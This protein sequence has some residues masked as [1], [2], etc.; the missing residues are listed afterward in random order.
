MKEAIHL[1]IDF[2]DEFEIALR[3][4]AES[5]DSQLLFPATGSLLLSRIEISS[6][7]DGQAQLSRE[8][9]LCA[10][11]T[12]GVNYSLAAIKRHDVDGQLCASTQALLAILTDQVATP[13]DVEAVFPHEESLSDA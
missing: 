9:I 8:Q 12:F 13:A 1:L 2:G 3:N 10:L 7:E 6:I 5:E 11:V 4:Q